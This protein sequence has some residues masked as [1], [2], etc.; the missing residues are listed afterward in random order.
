MSLES[1]IEPN[2]ETTDILD[3]T[4]AIVSAHLSNRETDPQEIPNLIRT[5]YQ[6]L[7]D[8][9]DAVK[10]TR[11]RAST[12]A[13]PIEESVQPD[14]IVCLE[15]GRQLRMLKRHLNTAYGLSIDEYKARWGLP[16][17]YPTVAPN[18]SKRRSAIAKNN[19][20]GN[21][22]KKRKPQAIAA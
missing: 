9:S 18:Y 4:T 17:D 8:L 13:V 21:T 11:N 5:I 10:P 6:T 22:P 15:D 1:F 7:S 19:G 12:P 20:L 2:T 3:L 14:Y 16:A